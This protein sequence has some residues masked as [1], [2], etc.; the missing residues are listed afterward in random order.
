MED[1]PSE[2]FIH[3][4]I[5]RCWQM[6]QER[7]NMSV[8]MQHGRGLVCPEDVSGMD[9]FGFTTPYIIKVNLFIYFLEI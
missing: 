5:D 1:C 7:V 8:Q 9:L 2:I 4:N 3:P 6:V